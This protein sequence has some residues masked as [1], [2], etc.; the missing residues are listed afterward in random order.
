MKKVITGWI[1][2]N[3]KLKN[4]FHRSHEEIYLGPLIW[5]TKGKKRDWGED[6]WPPKKVTITVEVE[7]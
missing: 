2:R 5:A 3:T 1:E 6:E 4:F 7:E